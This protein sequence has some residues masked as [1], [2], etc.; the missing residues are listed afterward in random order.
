[1]SG[2]GSSLQLQ[3][4]ANDIRTKLNAQTDEQ[5]SLTGTQR[6]LLASDDSSS[7]TSDNDAELNNPMKKFAS[8]LGNTT[9]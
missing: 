6:R 8:A 7:D 9:L 1:M 5:N 3:G 4:M 2:F